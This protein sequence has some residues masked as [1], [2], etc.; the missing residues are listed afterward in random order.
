[1][2]AGYFEDNIKKILM[3]RDLTEQMKKELIASV[4]ED[5]ANGALTYFFHSKHTYYFSPEDYMKQFN[6]FTVQMNKFYE[7]TQSRTFELHN[8]SQWLS[9][10]IKKTLAFER[11]PIYG[12]EPRH[13]LK[14]SHDR[15]AH[16]MDKTIE[17][18]LRYVSVQDLHHN[19]VMSRKN[20]TLVISDVGL[21]TM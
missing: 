12:D 17:W 4:K 7:K 20:G 13:G 21:F 16:E 11:F 18:L 5:V 2:F 14:L 8:I 9:R 10:V 19:N 15:Q 1:M 6:R 3:P